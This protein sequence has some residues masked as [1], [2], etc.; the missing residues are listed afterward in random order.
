MTSRRKQCEELLEQVAHEGLLALADHY[1]DRR[2]LELDVTAAANADQSLVEDVLRDPDRMLDVL[3]DAAREHPTL[4]RPLAQAHVRLS[5]LPDAHTL[6]VGEERVEELHRC[7]ALEGQ[8][9]KRTEVLPKLDMG[10]FDCQRCGER[11]QVEQPAFGSIHEPRECPQCGPDGYLTLAERDS[12]WVDYQ[13]VRLQQ[14]P[15]EALDGVTATIDIHITGDLCASP[16]DDGVQ[17]GMRATFVGQFEPV[18]V[19]GNTVHEKTLLGNNFRAEEQA[20]EDIDTDQYAADIEALAGRDDLYDRLIAS[21]APQHEGDLHVKEALMLQQFGGWSRTA[22]DG[23]YH[24]GNSHVFLIGDPGAGKTNLIEAVG[25]IAPRA[26]MTDGT[27]TSGA[28]LTAALV[29]DDF[30]EGEQWTIEAG[31]LP[32]A[33]EGIAVVDELDKGDDSDLDAIHTALES[34][35]VYVS[36]AGKQAT[37][38]AE[39]ALL[40][41][42]NPTGGHYDFT[43]HFAEQVGL[44]SPLLSRFDLVFVMT[45]SQNPDHLETVASHM[46]DSRT[47]AGKLARGES[48]ADVEREAIEPPIDSDVLT[49]YIAHA[50]SQARPVIRTPAVKNRIVEWFLDLKGK[51]PDRTEDDAPP[52][53]VTA[54]KLDAVCRLSEASARAALREEIT[55]DDVERATRLIDRSLADIGIAPDSQATFGSA[56]TVDAG[57]VGL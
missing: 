2:T 44:Q 50:R 52:L 13:K 33:H 49:A 55:T 8:V 22:P 15:E 17:A 1:P 35:R 53:P 29:K 24:R 25:E 3:T 30:S 20:Y 43:E 6:T 48:L 4:D 56:D 7:I 51:L 45:E 57:E 47:T 9:T 38:P 31:T 28:G 23:S 12:E 21:L 42:A 10:V 11:L 36:K 34:Q 16:D 27:G 40:A 26:A 5:N 41:A 32:L 14:P 18:R 46:V 39:T 19:K 54:R 37:L